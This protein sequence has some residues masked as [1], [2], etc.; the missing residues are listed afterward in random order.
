MKTQFIFTFLGLILLGISLKAQTVQ[1][2]DGNVYR[3]VIIGEQTWMAENLK[4]T[5]YNDGTDIPIVTD[6]TWDDLSTGAYCWYD[7]TPDNKDTYGAL[8]NWNTV[9]TGKLCPVGWHVPTEEEWEVLHKY[10]NM[11]IPEAEVEAV[12]TGVVTLEIKPGGHLKIEDGEVVGGSDGWDDSRDGGVGVGHMLKETGT[13]HWKDNNGAA[14]NSSGFTA[15]PGG[16]R[17][18]KLAYKFGKFRGIGVVGEWWSSSEASTTKAHS[19]SL[20]D[21]L[22]SASDGDGFKN[23]GLSVRCV[24]D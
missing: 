13:E 23:D 4:T 3:T 5:K 19:W 24:K 1:D 11:S 18:S 22:D 14:T 7:D 10:L 16:K 9:N 2:I 15:L 17:F 6:G 12:S 21:D 8:Y 20:W